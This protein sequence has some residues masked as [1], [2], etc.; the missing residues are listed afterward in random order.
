MNI[1]IDLVINTS[2][3]TLRYKLRTNTYNVIKLSIIQMVRCKV[4]RTKSK[5]VEETRPHLSLFLGF[6]I[7]GHVHGEMF[8]LSHKLGE[9]NRETIGVIETP[10]NVA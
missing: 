1:K 7:A 6:F 8:F 10:C 5:W 4:I 2:S 3:P 9:V